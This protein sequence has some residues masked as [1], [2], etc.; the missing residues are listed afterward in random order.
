MAHSAS[1]TIRLAA[2]VALAGLLAVATPSAAGAALAIT[3]P[4]PVNLGSV[5]AGTASRSAQLGMVTVTASGLVFPDFVATVSTTTFVTGGGT[6]AET[7]SKASVAYW[8]GPA[9][10]SSGLQTPLP[11]QLTALQAQS[12]SVSRTA[13][14]ST[15]LAL[16]I[17]TSWN[18][19]IVITIPAAAIAGTYTGTITHSVA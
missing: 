12:L 17:S 18:P 15:G 14:G 6:A 2:A 19:T 7:I 9:T 1:A 3:V 11:G 4:A 16:S 10:S 13:F 8:S 5:P